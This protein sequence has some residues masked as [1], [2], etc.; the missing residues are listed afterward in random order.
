[1]H[2]VGTAVRRKELRAQ[3]K[4]LSLLTCVLF[5]VFGFFFGKCASCLHEHSKLIVSDSLECLNIQW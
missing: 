3:I 2:K 5:L 1:M 4:S